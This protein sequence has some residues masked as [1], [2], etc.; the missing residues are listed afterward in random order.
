MNRRIAFALAL[1]AALLLAGRAFAGS[2]GAGT[3]VSSSGAATIVTAEGQSRS[4]KPGT[5]IRTGEKLVTGEKGQIN[6]KFSDDSLVLLYAQSEFR[7]DEY[8]F[9]GGKSDRDKGIFSLIKG[10]FR[11]V[12][13][14]I[15]KFNRSNYR[16]NT[17]MATI[18]IRGTE[19]AARLENGLHVQVDRGEISLSN[20]AGAF[21]VSEGQRAYV[22]SSRTAPRYINLGSSAQTSGGHGGSGGAV[23]IQG[24][25]NINATAKDIGAVSMGQDNTASNKTGTIGGK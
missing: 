5:E 3:V 16:V 21:A 15:G 25:T 10:G 18:G 11:T 6:I 23:N 13:G 19:Y 17:P 14:W 20:K 7:V 2:A 8:V 4:A 22:A 9:K 1:F 24:N 12:T